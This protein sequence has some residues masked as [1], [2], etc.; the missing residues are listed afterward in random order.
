MFADTPTATITASPADTLRDSPA[1][2]YAPASPQPH[3]A[4]Q[5]GSVWEE[6]KH[7]QTAKN[8]ASQITLQAVMLP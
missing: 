8:T 7:R 2:L 3:T 4:E 6:G 1:S 5:C